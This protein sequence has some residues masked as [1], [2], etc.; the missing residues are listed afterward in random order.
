[1][2]PDPGS[3]A[4]IRGAGACARVVVLTGDGRRYD[5]GTPNW[6]LRVWRWRRT[7]VSPAHRLRVRMY[8]WKRRGEFRAEQED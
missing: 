8:R 2:T 3:T 4:R 1:M 5:L 7:V 6:H